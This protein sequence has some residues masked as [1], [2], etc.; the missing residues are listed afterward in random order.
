MRATLISHENCIPRT[1]LVVQWLRICLQ[2]R[3]WKWDWSLVGELRSHMP[4]GNKAQVLQL[5]SL[6]AATTG[7]APQPCCSEDSVQPKTP[8]KT[9]LN[10][11]MFSQL[12]KAPML[13]W[14]L[15]AAKNPKQKTTVIHPCSPNQRKPPC[16][17]EDSVQPKN[18]KTKNHCNPL[19]FSQPCLL[20]T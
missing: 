3:G 18:P 17:N 20:S 4:Q 16:C 9:H 5:E 1:Y 2:C 19:M 14:G 12:E 11:P 15:S 8:N 6:Q 10:P 7:T 13:Q